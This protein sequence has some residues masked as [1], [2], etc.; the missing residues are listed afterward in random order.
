MN[1]WPGWSGTKLSPSIFPARLKDTSGLASSVLIYPSVDD[2]LPLTRSQQ[3]WGRNISDEHFSNC[4]QR[5]KLQSI[6]NMRLMTDICF[7]AVKIRCKDFQDFFASNYTL[8]V[9][10]LY[11]IWYH[12]L[13]S[14]LASLIIQFASASP[15]GFDPFP[16]DD[17]P[18]SVNTIPGL[19]THIPVSQ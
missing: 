3:L 15:S 9:Q 10:Y 18:N 13:D 16:A 5:F 4:T 7:Y 11:T 8:H 1:S 6:S 12:K 2:M 14:P 19:A 17:E